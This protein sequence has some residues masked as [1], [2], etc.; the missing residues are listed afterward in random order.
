MVGTGGRGLVEKPWGGH[1]IGNWEAPN[2]V[3]CEEMN[4]D[5]N[6]GETSRVNASG[7]VLAWN[8]GKG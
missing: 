3:I 2:Q 7:W 6:S 1:V 8:K 5:V 4:K